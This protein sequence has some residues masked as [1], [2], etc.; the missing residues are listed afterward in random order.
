MKKKEQLIKIGK[1]ILFILAI[2]VVIYLIYK[3]LPLLKNLSTQEGKE[4]FRDK[5]SDLGFM[6]M[7]S[8]FALQV[9]QIFLIIIPGEPI[10]VLAGMC[11]GSI[12]GMVF[13]LVSAF[14]ITT[15]IV[16]MVNKF[17]TKFIYSF[18]KKEKIDKIENSKLFK[19]PKKIEKIMLILFLIPG[20]PKDLL[21]YMGGI[22]PIKPMRFIIISSL[23]RIPSVITS[24]YAG[25]KL[26]YGNWKF[27]IG[28]YI[29]TFILT[30][31]GIFI[32]SKLDK[33]KDTKEALETI[34]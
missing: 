4:E 15:A 14:I 27:M 29:V 3:F 6:G 28:I 8:L 23:A 17:G 21:V 22:L 1:L 25:E 32:W 19:N 34:K 20:T 7:L 11:Y 18:I 12:G 2:L 9:A 16:F 24:T 31:L 26:A 13:I 10:E 33:S 5:I 30:G